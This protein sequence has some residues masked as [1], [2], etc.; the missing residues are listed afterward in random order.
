MTY[1]SLIIEANKCAGGRTVLALL[2]LFIFLLL[3]GFLDVG[4]EPFST[5]NLTLTQ[6]ILSSCVGI[7]SGSQFDPNGRS[8]QIKLTA[9]RVLQVP[10]ITLG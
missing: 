7:F 9:K 10:H 6:F 2:R 1:I 5:L 8:S 3:V 4:H